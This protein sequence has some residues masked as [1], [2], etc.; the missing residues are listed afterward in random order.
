MAANTAFHSVWRDIR[1]GIHT[2]NSMY[3]CR[4]LFPLNPP[5]SNPNR[6]SFPSGIRQAQAIVQWQ[7][8]NQI[9]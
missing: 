1:M 5:T 3:I 8:Q 7:A 6:T 4:T 9:E 2:T